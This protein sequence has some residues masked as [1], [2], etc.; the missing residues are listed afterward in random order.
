[1]HDDGAGFDPGVRRPGYGLI[2]LRDR[3]NAL[4]DDVSVNSS[5]SAGTTVT[6]HIPL[7]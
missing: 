1:V 2:N 6:G 4:G 5:P 7:P 3:L